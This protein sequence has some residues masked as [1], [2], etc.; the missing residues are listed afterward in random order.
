[1]R[2]RESAWFIPPAN[3]PILGKRISME[4]VD[5]IRY[6][7]F[8]WNRDTL[9]CTVKAPAPIDT[10]F[11]VWGLGYQSLLSILIGFLMTKVFGLVDCNNFYVSSERLF[12]PDLKG[13]SAAYATKW[14][15]LAVVKSASLWSRKNHGIQLDIPDRINGCNLYDQFI[16]ASSYQDIEIQENPWRFLPDVCDPHDR[17]IALADLWYY[18]A[19]FPINLIE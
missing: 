12:L 10:D 17:I 4:N 19:R 9:A 16:F 15:E 11:N 3:R 7:D 13:K 5:A 1:M 2:L 18:P 14:Q 6:R 8:T